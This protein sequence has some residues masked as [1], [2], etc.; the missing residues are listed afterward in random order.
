MA[1]GDRLL[2]AL[3]QRGKE[4]RTESRRQDRLN[5]ATT[6]FNIVQSDKPLKER[7]QAALELQ[8]LGFSVSKDLLKAP[9]NLD[10][11][12]EILNIPEKLRESLTYNVETGLQTVAQALTLGAKAGNKPK[13]L[14]LEDIKKLHEQG[15]FQEPVFK[16][17]KISKMSP[18]QIDAY[19]N[20]AGIFVDELGVKLAEGLLGGGKA[21]KLT[22]IEEKQQVFSDVTT[23]G[24]GTQ[25]PLG[26]LLKDPGRMG[27]LDA[28]GFDPKKVMAIYGVNTAMYG[29]A[30]KSIINEL[31]G[32]SSIMWD[33]K[34]K[35]H[36]AGTMIGAEKKRFDAALDPQGDL[37]PG[38]VVIRM[39]RIQQAIIDQSD[40][41]RV[42]IDKVPMELRDFFTFLAEKGFVNQ[43]QVRDYLDQLR[44]GLLPDQQFILTKEQETQLL[45]YFSGGSQ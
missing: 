45:E 23:E 14:T 29:Q 21:G 7:R 2:P 4:R 16:N 10:P 1:V 22:T 13:K 27:D 36:V 20:T 38:A 3:L 30:E 24:D 40:M 8:G 32:G 25:I 43:Q 6:L 39:N 37:K 11:F 41:S 15:F 28:A 26:T 33:I 9:V 31:S 44:S 42:D 5:Q 17:S 12:F 34:L 19:R 35:K 18:E